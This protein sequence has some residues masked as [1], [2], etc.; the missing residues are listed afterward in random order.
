MEEQALIELLRIPAGSRMAEQFSMLFRQACGIAAPKATYIVSEACLLAQDRVAI[1][2]VHLHGRLLCGNL[3]KSGKVFPFVATCGA[4]LE[5]WSSGIRNTMHAFWAD[6]IMFTALGCAVSY[7]E[8]DLR[9]KT[10]SGELSC[11]NPGSLPEWPLSEQAHIFALLGESAATVGVRL[12]ENMSMRPLKSIS[13][14]YFMSEKGFCNCELCLRERCITR[15]ASYN[16]GQ[17][18][19]HNKGMSPY[20]NE[21]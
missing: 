1:G 13:G 19:S 11:M 3:D 6:G 12:M 15:R 2:G 18:M 4:E 20:A 16:A 9:A 14:I 21:P 7:L 17:R 5:A 8:A 10:G